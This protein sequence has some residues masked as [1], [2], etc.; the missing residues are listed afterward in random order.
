MLESHELAVLQ[1][2]GNAYAL[3]SILPAKRERWLFCKGESKMTSYNPR[4]TS[5][6]G[7]EKSKANSGFRE[8]GIRVAAEDPW[9]SHV[10]QDFL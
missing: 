9:L 3:K 8:K 2:R 10:V 4:K 7:E 6:W 5:C 1:F